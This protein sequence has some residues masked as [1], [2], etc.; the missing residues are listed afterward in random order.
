MGA[1]SG[2]DRG[3]RYV[4]PTWSLGSRA[5][6]KPTARVAHSETTFGSATMSILKSFF[7]SKFV[8]RERLKALRTE[9]AEIQPAADKF[10]AQNFMSSLPLP[11]GATI[12]VYHSIGDELSTKYLS[13]ILSEKGH[14]LALPVTPAKKAPLTFKQYSS[15]TDLVEGKYGIMTPAENIP[16]VT[17]M[18]IVVPLLGFSR[19]GTRLGYGG[20]YYDRT[21][22]S[23]RLQQDILAVGFGFAALEVD[24]LPS[25]R[26]DQPLDWIVTEQEAIEVRPAR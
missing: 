2:L 15:E 20:G 23:L 21:L 19:N 7:D 16:D 5:K 12:A 11:K 17:P 4:V 6:N 25:S 24:A 3:P 26:L 18:I 22:A 13:K 14:P 10:A 1:A 8:W 9:A